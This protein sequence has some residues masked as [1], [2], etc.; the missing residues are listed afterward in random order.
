[1]EDLSCE[2]GLQGLL[3]LA[4]GSDAIVLVDVISFST[5]VDVAVSRGASVLPYRWR[6]ASAEAFAA[7]KGAILA[8]S[9]SAQGKYSLSPASLESI[10]QQT[11][12]VL[13]SPN[14]SALS[15][16]AGKAPT[17]TA[18]LRNCAAVAARVE[19]YG[20]RIAVIP[21]GEQWNDGSLRPALEDLIG[22]GALLARLP[23]SLS[24]EAELAV[25]AFERFRFDLHD[26]LARS[27]SG[28]ELLERGYTRDI[29]LAAAYGASS[30]VPL[31]RDDRFVDDKV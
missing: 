11:T 25:A 30:A 19:R 16:R 18:C 6:D 2:W 14:G 8:S 5:A 27:I 31:L 17:F 1:M 4:P 28:R 23:G 24:P 3:A 9:R 21:A 29:E 22:A 20:S 12:L 10:S 13:S 7:S 15:L 26:A